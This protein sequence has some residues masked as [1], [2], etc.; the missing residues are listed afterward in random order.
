MIP[1]LRREE[2]LKYIT[3][4]DVVHMKDLVD[5]LGISLSTIRRDLQTMEKE[6]EVIIMRGGAVR[7]NTRGY[8]EPVTKKKLINS[9]AKEII[10][11][12]AA[13]LVEDGDCIY[14]DSG[15]T[16][17]AMLKYL[18]RKRITI[19]SSSTQMLDHL[20][21][22]GASS[23]L[24]GGEVRDDLE[25]VL[26]VLTE[27]MI[28]DLHFDKAFIGANGYV[29]DGA[30]Y[31]YDLREARKKEVVKTQSKLVYALM[32]TSKKNKYAFAKVFDLNECILITEEN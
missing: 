14:V 22:R 24:L 16:T 15:T 4:Q 17:V 23:I 29:E 18:D 6:G 25:S 31:T 10:A 1:E 13:D 2:L 28:M 9:E 27:K 26:G 12:K 5:E 3:K 30:I 19:V 32:D 7:L 11:K 8:D 20:P 21:I